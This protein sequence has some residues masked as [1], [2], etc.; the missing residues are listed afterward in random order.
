MAM[1]DPTYIRQADSGSL[2]LVS[3]V[4]SLEHP[5]QLARI[6]HIKPNPVVTHKN[7]DFFRAGTIHTDLNRSL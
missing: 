2:K 1:D 3:P 7:D 4:Q 5:K 6:F